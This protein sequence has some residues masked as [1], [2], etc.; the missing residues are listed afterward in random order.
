MASRKNAKRYAL[1][2]KRRAAQKRR[3]GQQRR[4]RPRRSSQEFTQVIGGVLRAMMPL[5]WAVLDSLARQGVPDDYD[6][7]RPAE[8]T[9]VEPK[10]LPAPEEG[11]SSQKSQERSTE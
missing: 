6:N 8:F 9:V 7:A 4:G 10:A 2:R 5:A 11:T 3:R 1:K